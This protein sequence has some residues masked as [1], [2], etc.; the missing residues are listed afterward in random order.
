MSYETPVGSVSTGDVTG[1]A[2]AVADDIVTF[3][4]ATGKIIKDS[5][6]VLPTGVVVGTT[7]SQTLTNKTL[8]SPT[9]TTPALGTP[10]SGV[11]TNC[12]GLPAA[13]LSGTIPAAVLG[14]SS[15]FIGTTSTALNRASASQAL[16]GISSVSLP[17]ATSGATILQPTAIA[18]ATTLTLPS[19]TDT[20]VGKATTDTLTNK[21]FD[22]AGTGNSFSINGLAATANT[23]T[24]SVVRATG[25]TLSAPL[26]GTPASGT[27]TNCTGLPVSTGVS[28]LGTGIATF[29]ATPSSANLASAV[30]NETGSG[31][32]VFGTSPTLTTKATIANSNASTSTEQETL[33]IQ[34]QTSGT[35]AAGL[36]TQVNFVLQDD[37]GNLIYGGRI[38]NSWTNAGTASRQA[39]TDFYASTA[40]TL[41]M[42]MSI[43]FNAYLLVGYTLS[44]GAYKLQVNSQIFATNATIATS[45]GRYKTNIKPLDEGLALVNRLK[46]V[47][48]NWLKHPVHDFDT[49][50]RQIGFIAQDLAATLKKTDFA[51]AVV[52][53]NTCEVD[54]KKEDFLG[55]CDATLIPLLVKA[56]QDLSAKVDELTRKVELLESKAV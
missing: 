48:F 25:P 53:E 20:L 41:P 16:T 51:G 14:A 24:G 9:L 1:P 37:G 44:N 8:T 2:G 23:G 6:K 52:K 33:V 43:D 36:G 3:N 18:G 39:R 42:C 55:V 50:K 17:G 22:T 54:G 45:D 11:L 12:T 30:T 29:L 34:R 49:E 10:A 4:G 7:D 32:L 40:N 31:A 27:L 56:V 35:A 46:P 28:G 13:Q 26:L 38:A 21:T 5:G 15:L 47:T 19:A